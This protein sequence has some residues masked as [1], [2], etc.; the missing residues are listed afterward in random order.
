MSTYYKNMYVSDRVDKSDMFSGEIHNEQK[1][2]ASFVDSL[3]REYTRKPTEQSDHG[4]QDEAYRSLRA[5]ISM[6]TDI[7]KDLKQQLDAMVSSKAQAT[8][9]RDN[10]DVDAERVRFIQFYEKENVRLKQLNMKLMRLHY[11]QRMHQVPTADRTGDDLKKQIVRLVEDIA[12]LEDKK[13]ELINDN[14]QINAVSDELIMENK[15]LR[16]ELDIA[17]T[18][19]GK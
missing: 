2:K 5:D 11:T 19:L 15:H 18:Q 8:E 6:L 1:R 7:V 9:P 17:R 4:M 14:I 10:M 16:S 3:L 12:R 13:V